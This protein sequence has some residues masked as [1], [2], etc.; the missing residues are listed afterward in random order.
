MQCAQRGRRT[1]GERER[2]REGER[3][4]E[5]KRW[6]DG[7]MERGREGERERWRE[8]E[9]DLALGHGVYTKLQRGAG[10][11]NVKGAKIAVLAIGD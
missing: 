8:G 1:E 6:R 5:R 4:R 2:R 10:T 3:E 11:G 9:F 7:E